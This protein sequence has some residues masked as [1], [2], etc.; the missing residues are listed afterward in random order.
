MADIKIGQNLGLSTMKVDIE[1]VS[2]LSKVFNITEF[3]PEFN[4]GKNSIVVNGTE[5]LSTS[6][7]ILAEAHDS[8][9]NYLFIETAVN[10]DYITNNKKYLLSFYVYE[11][12]ASGV[13]E[14][15]IVS[16]NTKGKTV[17]WRAN[18]IIN[19]NIETKSKLRFYGIPELVVESVISP[20]TQTINEVNPK[21]RSGSLY[22]VPVSPPKD[23]NV[24]TSNYRKNLIDYRLVD[25]NANFSSS[26]VNSYVNLNVKQIKDFNSKNGI[27]IND[28]ASILISAVKNNTTLLLN[29]PYTYN[30]NVAEIVSADYTI[31]Y[32]DFSYNTASF[33]SSNRIKQVIDIVG[34]TIDKKFSYAN[35]IYKNLN[36]FSGKVSKYKLYKK[37]LNLTADYELISDETILQKEILRDP[38][39][40]NKNYENLGN[41]YNQFHIGNFWFASSNNISLTYDNQT[42]IDSAIINVNTPTNTDYVIAK[43]NSTFSQRDATYVPYNGAIS[44]SAFDCNFIRLFKNTNYTLSFYANIASLNKTSTS[45]L[46]FYI[47]SSIPA[48]Q[49]DPNYDYNKGLKI[50]TLDFND[51]TYNKTSDIL[52][53][54]N[55]TISNDIA[56]GTL[57]IYPEGIKTAIISNISLKVSET[58]GYSPDTYFTKISFPVNTA[59]EIFEI[60]SELYD[61]TGL[62]TYS[63]LHTI[64]TFDLKGE[65]LPASLSF[66]SGSQVTIPANLVVSGSE[67][68]QGNLIVNGSLIA[69]SISASLYGTSSWSNNSLSASYL[70]GAWAIID[71]LILK[72]SVLFDYSSSNNFIILQNP[73][74][75]Y[76]SAFFDYTAI[77][78]SNLRAGTIFCCFSGSNITYAEYSTT[79]IGNT[80]PVTMSADLS[81]GYIRL[82]SNYP[83]GQL[84]NVKAFGRYL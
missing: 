37:S 57:V 27:Y 16:K 75:S 17:R 83:A 30:N 1:D 33:G 81:T 42:F 21:I 69:N 20:A 46:V 14:I 25:I 13:G 52:Q 68:V 76:N 79:D 73:I 41:F 3:S 2:Y 80:Y 74:N 77:S 26:L 24:L 50:A 49:N 66:S 22:S 29:T 34:N 12:N 64:Q 67:L 39:T 70:S 62:L 15:I 54:F 11:Q 60:K 59:G 72:N 28:T 63:N 10:T 51:P 19:N 6:A 47:T 43:V 44:G 36:T 38:F 56:G 84:W 61:S 18:I 53:R 23:F 32:N 4:V 8:N 5:Y 35:I 48:I 31:D 71:N 40:P 9:G 55:F 65:T 58:F 78:S 7:T 45:K 82:L